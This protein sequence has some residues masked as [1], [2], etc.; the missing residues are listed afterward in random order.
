MYKLYSFLIF[1]V[2]FLSGC[3]SYFGPSS[4]KNTHP[5]YNQAIVNSLNQQMLLN[6]VRLKYRDQSYF[7]KIGSITS[8]LTMAANLGVNSEINMGP[9]AGLIEPNVG[10]SYVDRPTISYTPL[11]GEDFLKSILSS[12]SLEAILVMSQSGWSV[13][14]IFGICIERMNDL[15]NAPRASGPTPS[16]EP[17]YK[18]FKQMLALFRELQLAGNMEIGP[19]QDSKT[20][21]MDLVMLFKSADIDPGVIKELASLLG[22]FE[23]GN[24]GSERVRISNNFLNLKPDQLTVRTRSISSILFYLSQNIEIPEAHINAGLVTVTRS[25]QG[26]AFN[27]GDTPAGSVFKIR[28]SDSFPQNAYLSIPYRGAWFYIADNDLQSKST[29]MLLMQL[30]DLQAGQSKFSGPTLTLPVR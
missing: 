27:W 30:F 11:Q 15:Y 19:D 25:A 20:K 4:L 29:F 9:A 13:E 18:E 12:I 1:S 8:A 7:L 5:A 14:R 23:Q 2:V 21:K 3:Q 6:L 22:L 16:G 24:Q 26:G 28:S 10:L 17:E